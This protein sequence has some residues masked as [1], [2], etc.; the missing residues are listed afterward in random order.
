MSA[1][2]H[3]QV[4]YKIDGKWELLTNTHAASSAEAIAETRWERRGDPLFRHVPMKT[5]L[6]QEKQI[7]L[8]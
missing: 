7:K 2:N 3:Y 1:Y 6:L 4:L 5:W 8:P